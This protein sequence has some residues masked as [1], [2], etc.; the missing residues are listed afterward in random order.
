MLHPKA[1]GGM[2]LQW[3]QGQALEQ[4]QQGLLP[5]PWTQLSLYNSL[6][7]LLVKEDSS[8]SWT[9]RPGTPI[10]FSRLLGSRSTPPHRHALQPMVLEPE[11]HLLL[12]EDAQMKSSR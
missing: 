2:P 8:W 4:E 5:E 9:S 1:G 6:D 10:K 3:I 7:P 11:R 12:A